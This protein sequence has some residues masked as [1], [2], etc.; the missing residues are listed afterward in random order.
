MKS[1]SDEYNGL[2]HLPSQVY[3]YLSTASLSAIRLGKE[4]KNKVILTYNLPNL[5]NVQIKSLCVDL[6]MS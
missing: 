1:N 3:W 5:V 4:K 6:L 2:K